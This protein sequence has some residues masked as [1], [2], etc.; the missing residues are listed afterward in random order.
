M[1]VLRALV[2]CL[3]SNNK[4]LIAFSMTSFSH[5]P[6]CLQ[7]QLK[8]APGGVWAEAGCNVDSQR[9]SHS[10]GLQVRLCLHQKHVGLVT[11]RFQGHGVEM[12]VG[13]GLESGWKDTL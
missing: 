13:G 10:G 9:N 6:Y 2:T 1:T 7:A 3:Y 8:S 4:L 12:E 11:N 5:S